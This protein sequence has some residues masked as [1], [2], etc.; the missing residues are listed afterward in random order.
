MVAG[1]ALIDAAQI[2]RAR[3]RARRLKGRAPAPE[4]AA[5]ET[6]PV[7]A[8]M[9]CANDN[10]AGL[11]PVAN[12]VVLRD[13]T[14]DDESPPFDPPQS[15]DDIY[16]VDGEE[17]ELPFD[18]P[19]PDDVLGTTLAFEDD[20]EDAFVV[21]AEEPPFD[22]PV[23][24]EDIF[25]ATQ[26]GPVSEAPAAVEAQAVLLPP[27]ETPEAPPPQIEPASELLLVTSAE[28]A[29]AP[30]LGKRRSE[31]PRVPDKP[32]PPISI[33]ASWDRPAMAELLG[34]AAADARLTRADVTLERGG[35]DG[36]IQR[37]VTKPSPDLLI[38][39]TTLRAQQV[40]D[41][42]DRLAPLLGEATK[43]IV[44]GAVNDVSLLRG[45]A[46]RGVEYIMAPIRQD[47][48]I[49]AVCRLYADV[50]KA[51]VIAIVGARGGVGASTLAHNLAWS[52][53]ER[54]E[55]SAALI[56]FDLSFGTAAF[57]FDRH[58]PEAVADA[59]LAPDPTDEAFL[60]RVIARP[61]PR[62]QM[63]AP[64]ATL[65]H[66]F[67]LDTSAV[68]LVVRRSRRMSEFVV[69]D[70]P[71]VWTTWMRQTLIDADE[72]IIV[73]APDLAS[74]RNAKGMLDQLNPARGKGAEAVVALSMLG[75]PKRP[76]IS[77][78]D[79]AQAIGATPVAA[80]AFEP[81]LFATSELKGRM[82]G[83][84]APQS[85]AAATI[86]ALAA[87]LTGRQAAKRK[88]MTFFAKTP[89]LAEAEAEQG[90]VK[91]AYLDALRR[92]AR[93]NLDALP[94]TRKRAGGGIRL[95]V[96][97]ASL[98]APMLIGGWYIANQSEAAQNPPPV[99]AIVATPVSDPYQ[100]ALQL[101]ASGRA[102]EAAPLLRAAADHGS[103]RA[104]FRLAKLYE[105]GEGVTA[106]IVMARELTARAAAGGNIRAMHDLGVYY[107]RGEG[108]PLDE[109]A[110]YR[111]FRQAADFGIADS[112]F[113][114]GILYAQGRG[115]VTANAEEAL[116]WFL[117]AARQGDEAAAAR[118][119]DLETGLAP[120][121]IEAAR[122]RVTAFHPREGDAAA[123]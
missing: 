91:D 58:T 29:P 112:Q 98:I 71:H 89:S 55:A 30:T 114:L 118:V 18:P 115:G 113:N 26:I 63:L 117:L 87:A 110:A 3:T 27:A 9:P 67:E 50:D 85:K 17:P 66:P 7:A 46:A 53:A 121:Q 51:R 23:E 21:T 120:A 59:M 41:G 62:L 82:I 68:E 45:L 107:A 57:N 61:T 123:N 88:A 2:Q 35:I 40:L 16:R 122:M 108:A 69:L 103:A 84:I 101:I 14:D 19:D 28:Q 49:R 73:A 77:F 96:A 90:P 104:Q 34:A 11:A 25:V 70:L 86:D 80:L 79:F 39:D 10:A 47:D 15:H 75:A 94:D 37:Y 119:T 22:P 44:L 42:L 33:H 38:I 60:E 12:V 54:F 36:A 64:P 56:D 111:W 83:E 102:V 52:I 92:T 74:L 5:V 93:E 81:T 48:L 100:S 43:I 97:A 109:A 72:V 105:H 24:I 31:A 106:D 65:G 95:G 1:R 76:E 4:A 6:L 116:F 32:V 99:V 8:P 78:K 20:K 13:F